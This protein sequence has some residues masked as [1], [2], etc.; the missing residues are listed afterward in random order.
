MQFRLNDD[1]KFI[2]DQL[3]KNGTGFLVGGALRDL[4]LGKDPGDYDF[5]TDIDYKNLKK[6]FRNYN[7]KEVGA[8]FGILM[9]NV[10][11][12]EY[13]IAKFRQESGIY[14]SRYPKM[15]RFIHNVE[16]DLERRDFTINA[17]AY[18]EGTGLKDLYGGVSDIKNGIIKFVGN[19]KLR[20]E[21]DSLRIMRAFRFISKLGFKLDKKTSEAIFEKRRFLN[22]ISKERIFDELKKILLGKY[23]KK[24]LIEMKKLGILELIIPEFR[25]VYNMYVNKENLFKKIIK[26]VELSEN[27][28]ITKL[29]SLFCNLGMVNTETINAK[30]VISYEGYERES[31]VIA[32]NHLK[33]LKASNEIICSV[34]KIVRNSVLL[35]ENPTKKELK[36]LIL[37][38]GDKN[39]GRLFNLMNSEL[40]A[41]KITP[42][43]NIENLN[44][45]KN[46]VE[47]IRDEGSVIG[48]KEVDVTGVD[49]INLKFE[50][51]SIG[52]LKSEVYELILDEKLRNKK[53]EIIDYLLKKYKNGYKLQNEKSCGAVIYNKNLEKYL[54]VKMYNGNWGFPKGHVEEGE[55]EIETAI[56]EVKEETDIDIQIKD[57]FRETIS[58]IPNEKTIKEVVFFLGIVN[59]EKLEI[60]TEEIED[61]KWCT[62][63]EALKL[64][65]YKVQRDVLEKVSK[66]I[67]YQ[68]EK[69]NKI[70]WYI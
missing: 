52:K 54:I 56:R 1:V 10:N 64:I 31:M 15:I 29:A 35:Y 46:R 69:E 62:C 9:I 4:I 23:V 55:T 43:K 44:D 63:E 22:K 11:G 21:E 67:K 12:K 13:E 38:F 20:I 53:R 14:N 19:P 26:T 58:Y 50:S 24:A 45:L 48:I 41:R 30:G 66:H 16:L 3:N 68:E 37:D 5:A 39:I 33:Y 8:H 25:Y 60:D 59:S 27:E 61:F 47:E 6:I 70:L 36:K 40:K 17:L 32:E 34:K 51:K 57:S 28:L 49:L 7:P 2:L 18:S 65:T 42:K